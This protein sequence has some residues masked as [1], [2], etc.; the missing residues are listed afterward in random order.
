[1][2][3]RTQ[4][5]R[6]RQG[7]RAM[8]LWKTSVLSI[9]L[10]ALLA[11]GSLVK[12]ARGQEP[13]WGRDASMVAAGVIDRVANLLSL[14]RPL[15]AANSAL[16]REDVEPEI[17]FPPVTIAPATPQTTTTIPGRAV[18]P[19]SP[20]RM[21]VFG[22]SVADSLAVSLKNTAARDPL[23]SVTNDGR[24]STGLARPDY[25]NWPEHLVKD[26]LP[27]DPQVMVIMF[28][29]N[30]GQGMTGTDGKV[31][32]RG[33]PEWLDEYRRRV[34]ATM[35][36]LKDPAN[37]RLVI[38][39]G[40]PVMR[41]GSGVHEMDQLDYIYWTEAQKRPWIQYFDSWPFFSDAN[42]Q[43]VKEAPFADGV[44]RGLRQKDGVHL[45]TIGG[46]RLSWA[47]LGRIGKYVDLSA[48]KVAPPADEAPAAGIVE[49]TEIP[50]G[51]PGA[52]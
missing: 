23:V 25:Y 4:T 32:T 30:D 37:D 7:M 49:R 13:G 1:M 45:S 8:T 18:S 24:V 28:G 21:R 12:A 20:L 50:P 33:T 16:G 29:A 35:D 44:S 26:V 2:P 6:I 36:L 22:D 15:D 14:N 38:W 31:Y 41:P 43:Y 48:G 27:S 3:P 46:N 5:R 52:E 42:L 17:K 40:A 51:V 19:G 11:S 10:F 47:V 39:V 34:A 9:A